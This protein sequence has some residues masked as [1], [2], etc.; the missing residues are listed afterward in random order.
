MSS[1]SKY[2]DLQ[3]VEMI[4]PIY[5]NNPFYG[6][7]LLPHV[8]LTALFASSAA[9]ELGGSGPIANL[10]GW[11][12]DIGAAVKGPE[13]HHKTGADISGKMM[14]D[15]GFETETIIL[16]QNCLLSHRGGIECERETIEAKCVASADGL[17]HF[18]RVSDLFYVAFVCLKL[19]SNE[20]GEWV[21]NK[22]ERSWQKMIPQHKKL[23]KESGREKMRGNLDL[24]VSSW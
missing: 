1:I 6:P 11:L 20:A 17:V 10:A 4:K 22:L 21:G 8:A 5:L 23:V 13:D 12:H 7:T 9:T 2:N 18:C 19:N 16:V 24:C 3:L 14:K 15:M